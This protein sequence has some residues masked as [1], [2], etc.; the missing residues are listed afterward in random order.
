MKLKKLKV[1]NRKAF[2]RPTKVI[3]SKKIKSKE[4][5]ITKKELQ[6]FLDWF[7]KRDMLLDKE[8]VCSLNNGN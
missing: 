8:P 6:S 5:N 2:A 3:K 1:K 4:R 7:H